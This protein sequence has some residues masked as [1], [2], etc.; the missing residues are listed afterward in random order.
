[1]E[2]K[3]ICYSREFLLS[4]RD[5]KY[6]ISDVLKKTITEVFKDISL[7][8]K[9]K[10]FQK[11]WRKDKKPLHKHKSKN[12]ITKPFFSSTRLPDKTKQSK[13]M[14]LLNKLGKENTTATGEKILKMM[15]TETET[16]ELLNFLAKQSLIQET[17]SEIMTGLCIYIFK[18]KNEAR[19]LF[20]FKCKSEFAEFTYNAKNDDTR[21]VGLVKVLKK[22]FDENF[23]N[24]RP[25]EEICNTFLINLK[26][27]KMSRKGLEII[28]ES[29]IFPDIIKKFFK[30][31]DKKNHKDLV[32][33]LFTEPCKENIVLVCEI[34]KNIDQQ[35]IENLKTGI[36]AFITKNKHLAILLTFLHKENIISYEFLEKCV[37]SLSGHLDTDCDFIETCIDSLLEILKTCLQDIYTNSQT[38]FQ[39]I[40][41]KSSMLKTDKKI[42]PKVR[43]KFMDVL[44]LQK[45]LL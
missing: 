36:F 34:S 26:N 9:K 32:K 16:L 14:G 29:N 7:E 6:E 11:D 18:N 31:L 24:N 15:T 37:N 5:N 8:P 25:F 44:D 12:T 19:Q 38:S 40:I 30:T 4:F 17:V 42:P 23:I 13:I 35:Y 45:K 27:D 28:C 3:R 2:T 39:E 43:F 41:N 10:S 21:K 22:L 20:L 33:F 1:M